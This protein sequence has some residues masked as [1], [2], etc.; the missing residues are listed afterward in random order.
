MIYDLF[1]F[2]LIRPSLTLISGVP[3]SIN[4][5]LK[6]FHAAKLQT[7][8]HM[9]KSLNKKGQTPIGPASRFYLLSFIKSFVGCRWMGTSVP[10]STALSIRWHL[11]SSDW[12]KLKFICRRGESFALLHRSSNKLV[13]TICIEPITSNLLLLISAPPPPRPKEV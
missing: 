5:H 8:F 12:W 4:T 10:G 7:F 6:L 9:A 1:V 11:S 13:S 3:L 2:I